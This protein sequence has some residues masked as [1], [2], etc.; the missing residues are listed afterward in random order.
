MF[1]IVTRLQTGGPENCVFPGKEK[2]LL[3]SHSFQTDYMSHLA[4]Q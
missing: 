3:S 2:I 4:S 1:D